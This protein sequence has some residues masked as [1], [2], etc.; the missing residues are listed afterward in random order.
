M[1]AT[2]AALLAAV[3]P[4]QNATS[5][6]GSS[7]LLSSSA[8]D[9]ATQAYATQVSRDLARNYLLA[10]VAAMV[11]TFI[12]TSSLRLNQHIRRLASL[13]TGTQEYFTVPSRRQSWFKDHLFYAP[14]FQHRRATE[15]KL[16]KHLNL[17]TLPTRFQS[18]FLTIMIMA[19]V[20]VCTYNVPWH[21]SGLKVLP[22][23]RLRTGTLSVINL[24]P[25]MLMASVKNPL[26]QL[27][28]IS[29]DSF[30]L[31]HRWFG[32]M[33]I[34]QAI[35][36]TVCY[37]IPK[38]QEKGW[39]G[40]KIAL[41]SPFLYNGLISTVALALILF[42][43]PKMVR[44]WAYEAFLHIHIALVVVSLVFLWMH[45]H[46][47]P[48]RAILLGAVVIWIASRLMRLSTL[49]FRSVG[50]RGST[51]VIEA[52]PGDA[53]RI[54]I[55]AA[56]PWKYR[57]GQSMYV[58]LPSV[59]L[60]TAHPFSVAWNDVEWNK[61]RPSSFS[62]DYDEKKLTTKVTEIDPEDNGQ[63][64]M[65]IVVK[66]RSGLTRKLYERVQKAGAAQGNKLTMTAFVEGPY[67]NETSMASYGTVML[68]ASGVGITHQL[69][70]VK[71]LIDG[72]TNGTV[73]I[74]RLTLVW[75]VPG[76]ECLEWV[77]PWM[78]QIL[79]MEKRREVLKV[80]LYI[81]R[82]GSGQDIKSPSETVRMT[83]GRPD[84]EAL[85]RAEA[86]N[87]VGCMALSVCAGGALS[88]EVRRVSRVMLGLGMNLDFVEEGFGW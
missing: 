1:P 63:E 23:I 45:L 64:T 42:H 52:M 24:L 85:V 10:L 88:D 71:E 6:S 2:L 56:R 27:L 67:G 65:S 81:T 86:S 84:V 8:Q 61:S 75:V 4:E 5:S 53:L 37:A 15:T 32:R 57:P 7:A 76:T 29:Y 30:N 39:P 60:W 54:S 48:Q 34:L 22:V 11:L 31:M 14:L 17:G 78:H 59:G 18:C 55:S 66:K 51:A 49:L 12:Y 79:A 44:S 82:A 87:V 77:R 19:N 80:L 41:Q 70:Y 72:Y 73:A 33:C 26:I 69:P 62:S 16:A 50:R 47:F 74:R 38:G 68:F 40:I 9:V 43:G 25:I 46:G 3:T 21:D 58:T 20:F 35:V 36:H 83:R 13:S 28:H